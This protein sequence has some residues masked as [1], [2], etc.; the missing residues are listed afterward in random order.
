VREKI[1]RR[2]QDAAAGERED[3]ESVG[4]G[5]VLFEAM[6]AILLNG[7]VQVGERI[8]I[9]EDAGSGAEDPRAAAAGLPGDSEARGE[10]V[11]WGG[12]RG[13]QALKLIAEAADYGEAGNGPPLVLHP[14]GRGVGGVVGVRI[15]EGLKE[16]V[17]RAARECAE[18]GE[19]EDTG[20]AVG[21][22]GIEC[23][24]LQGRAG[25]E[26]VGATYERD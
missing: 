2:G 24:V 20:E 14:E 21:E 8:A 4:A 22:T 5:G 10:I 15:A 23:Y 6:N 18:R 1:D 13:G 16:K 3:A 7:F 12:E 25:A 17:G 19:E 9:V 11:R 26:L